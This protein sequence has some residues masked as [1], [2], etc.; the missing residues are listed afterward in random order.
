MAAEDELDILAGEYVIGA[1]PPEE[2]AAFE[3]RLTGEPELARRVAEWETRLAPLSEELPALAPPP[4]VWQRIRR[5]IAEPPRRAARVAWWDRLGVWRGW[6]VAAT[7]SA[8]ALLALLLAVPPAP[9]PELLAVLD[10]PE[11]RPLWVVQASSDA[12]RL[13]ARPLAEGAPAGR[14]PELWLLREGQVISLAILDSTG[15]S[16]RAVQGPA[17][18][19]LRP[20]DRLAVSIEPPGGSPTGRATGPVVSRGVLVAEPL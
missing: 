8:L 14:V 3:Q 11:G 5:S 9:E 10:D 6:A 19:M 16:E 13:L 18:G 2:R 1:L 4:E 12:S 7:A 20:G 17:R 15:T